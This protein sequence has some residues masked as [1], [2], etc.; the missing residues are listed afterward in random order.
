MPP[1]YLGQ[2]DAGEHD[3]GI[4]LVYIGTH[5]A[6]AHTA[7]QL[8]HIRCCWCGWSSCLLYFC[9]EPCFRLVDDD[10]NEVDLLDFCKCS[11]LGAASSAA[12][13]PAD[14]TSSSAR[15]GAASDCMVLLIWLVVLSDVLWRLMLLQQWQ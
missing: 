13:G 10:V 12:A 8:L 1:S 3:G 11:L 9:A 2:I 15:A 4:R 14:T 5:K 7:V 6:Q